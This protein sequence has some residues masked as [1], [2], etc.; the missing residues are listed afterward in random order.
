[1]ETC[2]L[3][4]IIRNSLTFL[5]EYKH[6][7]AQMVPDLIE[8][9]KRKV[10]NVNGSLEPLAAKIVF[11]FTYGGY[12]VE[13]KKQFIPTSIR[14]KDLYLTDPRK[15][16]VVSYK[17]KEG[18]NLDIVVDEFFEALKDKEEAMVPN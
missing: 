2:D 17:L 18:F 4:E 5:V 3:R 7:R 9:L 6:P 1:M 16:K 10:E 14:E 11:R 8:Y 12:L 15:Y 13:D